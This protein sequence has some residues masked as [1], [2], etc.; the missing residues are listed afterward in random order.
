M[1]GREPSSVEIQHG[2]NANTGGGRE[3]VRRQVL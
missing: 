3:A 2:S 1:G